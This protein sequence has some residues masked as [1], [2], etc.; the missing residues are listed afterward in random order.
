MYGLIERDPAL[1]PFESDIELRMTRYND[2]KKE[3]L[4]NEKSLN[5]F[6]NAHKWYGFHRE[7]DGWVYREWAPAADCLYLTGDFNDWHWTDTPLTKLLTA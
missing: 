6:A 3:L 1:A 5:D 7:K 4:K 2:K